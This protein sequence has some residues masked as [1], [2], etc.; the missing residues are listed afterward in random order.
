MVYMVY[1]SIMVHMGC[2]YPLYTSIWYTCYTFIDLI[3]RVFPRVKTIY[4]VYMV[5]LSI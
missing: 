5:C 1:I 2:I 4:M 3:N